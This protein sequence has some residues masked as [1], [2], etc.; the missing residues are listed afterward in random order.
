MSAVSF[1]F[2]D[3][4]NIRISEDNASDNGDKDWAAMLLFA[5]TAMS[6]MVLI[7]ANGLEVDRLSTSFPPDMWDDYGFQRWF[8]GF[9]SVGPVRFNVSSCPWSLRKGAA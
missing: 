6:E 7:D 8:R 1:R 4:F 2:R 9:H 3:S 5:S